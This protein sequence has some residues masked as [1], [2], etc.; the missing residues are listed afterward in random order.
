MKADVILLNPSYVYPPFSKA[1]LKAIYDDP[2]VMDLPSMEF[3]YPPMGLLSI[4]GAL[5]K[6]GFSVK[7]VDSNTMPMT[8]EQLARYCEGA[9][10]VGISLLVANLRSTYQLV[11]HMRGRGYEIVLGGGFRLR[12]VVVI[13]RGGHLSLYRSEKGRG[14]GDRPGNGP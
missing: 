2:L 3:L 11:Q 13:G 12:S 7:G 4:G 1:T 5:R 14:C 8:M 9:K 6:A 10:V